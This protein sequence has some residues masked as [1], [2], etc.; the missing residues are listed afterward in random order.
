MGAD[1]MAGGSM[2]PSGRHPRRHAWWVDLQLGECRLAKSDRR[3]FPD[4]DAF[5]ISLWRARAFLF[6]A[7][8][9]VH[10]PLA[11]G[12]SRIRHRRREQPDLRAFLPELRL[13]QGADD[14]DGL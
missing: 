9:L 5:P 8:A 12:R 13:D 10:S 7:T 11:L 2:V 6:H 14:R 1:R 4:L 3:T